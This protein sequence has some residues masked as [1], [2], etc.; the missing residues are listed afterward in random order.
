MQS[1]RLEASLDIDR[2]SAAEIVRII[3]AEDAT[4]AAAVAMAAPNIARAVDA[5]AARLSRGGRLYYAGAGTSGRIAQ[6]DAAELGP[7]FGV[8]HAFVEVLLAG[9][10]EALLH[11]VEGAED[12]EEQAAEEIRKRGLGPSDA[13]VGIAASGATPYT[14][15]AVREAR[16]RQALTIG[17]T[18]TPGSPLALDCDIPIVTPTGPE[19]ILGSTRM[20]SGTAQKMVLNTLSTGILIRL[21]RVYSNLMVHMPVSNQKLR[22]RARLMVELITG[23]EA[24][25]ADLALEQCGGSVPEA[26]V[27]VN[28]KVSAQ[29]ARALLQSHGGRLREA[30]DG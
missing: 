4:V 10:P 8:P 3:Q 14:L 18:S 24:G 12:R 9:G 6:L 5:V 22:R 1:E 17:V 15:R 16:S 21:G 27:V 29:E 25:A 20:K 13:L 26:V 19:V 2:L 30:L 28:K 11:A 7:T 23:A